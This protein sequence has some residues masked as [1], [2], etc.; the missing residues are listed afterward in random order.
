M[1]SR[2]TRIRV[3]AGFLLAGLYFYLAHP[4]WPLWLVGTGVALLGILFRAWA[5][6]A[7]SARTTNWPSPDPTPS[8]AI[9]STWAA[10]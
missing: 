3:P 6:P 9:L 4:T 7:T 2:L 10:L 1:M 5:A 8:P